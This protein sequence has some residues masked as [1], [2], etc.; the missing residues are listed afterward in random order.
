MHIVQGESASTV[1]PIFFRAIIYSQ[2][3]PN[4]LLRSQMIHIGSRDTEPTLLSWSA[5]GAGTICLDWF[6]VFGE[7]GMLQIEHTVG[8]D[9][10]TEALL[11]S[12][13]LSLR[14]ID[15]AGTHSSPRRP[16]A[17]EHVCA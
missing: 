4:S 3:S 13:I 11:D 5:A 9:R 2:M 7:S 1:S 12:Q 14:G 16:N 8:C 17:V 6:E 15:T 10:V